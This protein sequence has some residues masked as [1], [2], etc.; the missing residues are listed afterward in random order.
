MIMEAHGAA[1]LHGIDVFNFEA[2]LD[3]ETL[4]IPA[5]HVRVGHGR[6]RPGRQLVKNTSHVTVAYMFSRYHYVDCTKWATC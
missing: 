1:V 4:P 2:V 3:G 5:R 6:T